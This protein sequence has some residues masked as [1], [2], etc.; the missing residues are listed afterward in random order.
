VRSLDVLRQSD[1]PD[2]PVASGVAL[3]KL[4]KKGYMLCVVM[5]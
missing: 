5:F 1:P 3:W 4:A 2:D